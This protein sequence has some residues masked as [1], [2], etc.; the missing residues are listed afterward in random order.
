MTNNT[1]Y[2]FARI[3]QASAKIPP[4]LTEGVITPEILHRWER[5]CTN[6]FRHK[7]IRGGDQVE[8]VPSEIKDLRLSRWI[9]AV[10][11]GMTFGNFMTQLRDEALD[12]N[13]AR[14]LR[15]EIFRTRQDNRP[16]FDWVCEIE[17]KNAI[18][19]P[20]PAAHISDQQLRDHLEAQMDDALAQQC[21]KGF[22]ISITVHAQAPL[23]R[24]TGSSDR[25]WRT[26]DIS[27]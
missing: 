27:A 7:K 1:N 5:A 2:G 6:Y 14:L 19:S 17:A 3:H 16:F 20:V 24:R 22:I 13:W 4:T 26:P 21:Q 9:E 25:T 18:L 10:L 23:S 11:G 15:T 8:D 12:P